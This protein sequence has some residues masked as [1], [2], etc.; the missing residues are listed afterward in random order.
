MRKKMFKSALEILLAL[1]ASALSVHLLF[2]G[3]W[4]EFLLA[5]AAAC[6]LC[7]YS[8]QRC[9]RKHGV[10]QRGLFGLTMLPVVLVPGFC[11]FGLPAGLIYGRS[12]LA[13]V[14]TDLTMIVE[15]PQLPFKPLQFD[16]GMS[17]A[18][19]GLF[20]VL[21]R[22]VDPDKRLTAVMATNRMRPQM[23]IPLLKIAM[24]DAVDDVRLLAY[25]IK[26][27]HESNINE[28]IKE[29]TEGLE[30]LAVDSD[31]ESINLEQASSLRS[32]AFAYWELAYLELAEGEIRKFCLS[33]AIENA[34]KALLV[35]TDAPTAILLCRAHMALGD[36]VAADAALYRALEFGVATEVVM[37]H[38]AEIAYNEGRYQDIEPVLQPL[39][40]ITFQNLQEVRDYWCG[41]T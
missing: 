33:Q 16:A 40:E 14:A 28:Q 9:L 4:D 1:F 36:T 19:G 11:V 18:R 21:E 22:S 15:T 35:L 41:A 30:S 10:S 25:S 37:P 24:R 32:L 17:F 26:D 29:L 8:L 5:H 2:S 27:S 20:E 3:T 6:L 23:A 38:R 31:P 34:E 39:E 12:P 13:E 7:A